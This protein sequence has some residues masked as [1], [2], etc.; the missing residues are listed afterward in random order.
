MVNTSKIEELERTLRDAQVGLSAAKVKQELAVSRSE[1]RTQLLVTVVSAER[2]VEEFKTE[3]KQKQG[4]L[5]QARERGQHDERTTSEATSAFESAEA[6]Y[7]KAEAGERLARTNA[8]LNRLFRDEKAALKAKEAQDAATVA[9]N[10]IG[11]EKKHITQLK[12]LEE[13]VT[14]SQAQLD[15][16]ATNIR[17][18]LSPG[19]KAKL[20]GLAIESGTEHKLTSLA[21]LEISKSEI[22]IIPGGDI[23]NP[24]AQAEQDLQRLRHLLNQLAVESIGD[25]ESRLER[26]IN[27]AG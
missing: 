11:I 9:A 22:T 21:T 26:R 2:R 15:A 1:Q 27:L 6:D 12:K 18:K 20:D 25:A 3:L 19:L 4:V 13:A 17:V 16:I 14:R 8:D 10:A 23:S 24:R 7:R 5:Q